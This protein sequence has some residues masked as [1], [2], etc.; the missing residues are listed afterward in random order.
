M[1]EEYRKSIEKAWSSLTKDEVLRL[2][3]HDD[4]SPMDTP[5]LVGHREWHKL[6]SSVWI[7]KIIEKAT[8]IPALKDHPLS[9]FDLLLLVQRPQEHKDSENKEDMQTDVEDAMKRLNI[10][11]FPARGVAN[12]DMGSWNSVSLLFDP[13]INDLER[14]VDAVNQYT[15]QSPPSHSGGIELLEKGGIPPDLKLRMESHVALQ[16][17]RGFSN[18][19]RE[20]ARQPDDV[21]KAGC[22][23]NVEAVNL[24]GVD[25]PTLLVHL[26]QENPDEDQPRYRLYFGNL[27]LGFGIITAVS[28]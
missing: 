3:F 23:W 12:Q 15:L 28:Q 13:Q 18:R 11:T 16:L 8:N 20:I 14:K 1:A 27:P 9:E 6:A 17:G 7:A 19:W 10:K 22:R 2:A 26:V 24:L 5:S 21:E 4:L 25:D